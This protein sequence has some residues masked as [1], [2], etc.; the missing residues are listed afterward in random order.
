MEHKCNSRLG[1]K[2]DDGEIWTSGFKK[3][4]DA[5]KGNNFYVELDATRKLNALTQTV[6]TEAGSP[7]TL[8]FDLHRREDNR[9]ETVFN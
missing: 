9:D 2:N 7:Y 1:L 3:I 8:S 6:I 4:Y 5:T